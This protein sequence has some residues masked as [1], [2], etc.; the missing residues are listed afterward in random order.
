MEAVEAAMVASAANPS[1][2]IDSSEA[3]ATVIESAVAPATSPSPAAGSN[4]EGEGKEK[5]KTAA[6]LP[7]RPPQPIPPVPPSPQPHE[8]SRIAQDLQIRQ[9]QVEAVLHL[10][11]EHYAIPF[12]AR[13]RKDQ[14]GGLSEETIR[15]IHQRVRQ[16]RDLAARK[17]SIL[18]SL[19]RQHRLTEEL[20]QA[21]LQ[22]DNPKRL[23]DLYLPFRHKKKSAAQEAR[24]KG[25]GPVAEAIWNRD[26]SVTH[27]DEV[28]PGLVDP[29]K[30]LLTP[31]DVLTGI[32]NILKETIAEQADLRG[33]V[34]RFIW[35]TGL[36]IAQRIET[37]PEGKGREFQAF[38]DFKEPLRAIPPHRVLAIARGE[39]LNILRVHIDV[40]RS[41]V[42]EMAFQ[43]LPLL[44]HPH[45]DLLM[46]LTTSAVEEILLPSLEKEVRRDLLEQAQEHAVQIFAHNLR[47]LL[48]QPPVR[49]KKVLAID[50][51]NRQS[52]AVVVLDEQGRYIEDAIVSVA[53]PERQVIETRLRL[54]QLIRRHQVSLIAI[55]NGAHYREVEALV[56]DLIR[57]LDKG[58]GIS[59]LAVAA[60]Q[61]PTV[62]SPSLESVASSL[63]RPLVQ[64][65]VPAFPSHAEVVLTA[66]TL[67]S[68]V[69]PDA[70]ITTATTPLPS[71]TPPFTA[72][73]LGEPTAGT[74]I[75]AGAAAMGSPTETASSPTAAPADVAGTTEAAAGTSEGVATTNAAATGNVAPPVSPAITLAETSAALAETTI[76]TTSTTLP[77]AVPSIPPR[78]PIILTG[79]PP[80]PAD[81]AYTIVMEAGIRNYARSPSAQEEF[82]TLSPAIR[83]AISVG[84]R[85][86][87]PLAELVKIE[88]QDIG[89][90][91][92]Q[93]DVRQKYLRETLEAVIVSC[94][95]TVGVDLNRA[96]FP[97][98]RHVCGLNPTFAR[99][100]VSRRRQQGP[101][102]HRRQLLEIGGLTEKSYT[103]AAGF[104]RVCNGDEPLDELWIHPEQYDLARALL[105]ACGYTPVDLRD[106]SRVADLRPRLANIVAA[107]FASRFHVSEGTVRDVLEALAH[108]GR[109]VRDDHP[110]PVFKRGM[111]QFE[112]IRPG[113]ELRGTV[114]NVVPF[115]AFVDIGLRE[116]G[117]VHISQM[118]NRYIRTPYEVVAVGDVVTVW[119]LEVKPETRKISLTMIPP[120][121]ERRPGKTRETEQQTGSE[122]RPEPPRPRPGT[123]QRPEGSAPRE[124]G[125][126]PGGPSAQPRSG[127]GRRGDRSRPTRASQREAAPPPASPTPAPVAATTEATAATPVGSA[128]PPPAVPTPSPT[129][130]APRRPAP[131]PKPLPTLPPEKRS[132]KAALNTFAELAAYFLQQKQDSTPPVA[133]NNPPQAPDSA[134]ADKESSPNQQQTDSPTTTTP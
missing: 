26:P 99:E 23:E 112:D 120:G 122:K 78:R 126:R 124:R 9:S 25:L 24:D 57:E 96:E 71:P 98:L 45:R 90:G 43:L 118:A 70:A 12:I 104:V 33:Q 67:I 16:C 113:M 44:D 134:H 117:L 41:R 35:E 8:L 46:S 29:D 83:A 51:H 106:P 127:A 14:T 62:A 30:W 56:S 93:H 63:T 121:Q 119:V 84:R 129:S 28:L 37:V 50:P 6:A 75:T 130:P 58:G 105:E 108:P 89:V 40:D 102:R 5:S 76:T 15:R 17:H 52:A 47:S 34:R 109:D 111:L 94:V 36:L 79:L 3:A 125:R 65:Q 27:L 100:I 54:E 103:Q 20:T 133:S 85:V 21:I 10:L 77:A 110:L 11:D 132:G 1:G 64:T 13:Y 97:L 48:L 7:A 74:D 42:K 60:E 101:F 82:P 19:A 68:P 4:A 2:V 87:D 39:R 55:G 73:V 131:K 107:E 53:G 18:R 81:L 72:T 38:F 32:K 61:E 128:A 123:P 86:L 69:P 31:D 115:G 116:S 49:N 92:Y 88:P 59:A 80:A 91:L 22:A 95:N 114:L 66:E